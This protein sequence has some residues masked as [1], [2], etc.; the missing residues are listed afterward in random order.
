MSRSKK[1][2]KHGGGHR[3][4]WKRMKEYWGRRGEPMMTPG[5]WSKQRTH[6]IER[7]ETRAIE[8]AALAA[9]LGE[10]G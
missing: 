6:S 2:G 9:A 1:D 10:E 8:R 5:R 4:L 7:C 3:S